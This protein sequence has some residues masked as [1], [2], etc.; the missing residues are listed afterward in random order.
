[1]TAPHDPLADLRAIW[2]S[3]LPTTEKAALTVLVLH[4][5]NGT[6]RCDPSVTRIAAE[7]SLGRRRTFDVLANLTKS[8]VIEPRRRP[9]LRN[10]YTL[11]LELVRPGALVQSTSLVQPTASTGA[12]QCT[13]V[14]HPTAPELRRNYERTTKG[15]GRKRAR[16]VPPTVDEVRAYAIERGRTLDADAFAD[17]FVNYNTAAGWQLSK[18]KP[19]VDWRAAVR[20]WIGRDVEQNAKRFSRRPPQAIR[21]EDDYDAAALAR[22]EVAHA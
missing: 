3:D 22:P 1:M 9:G 11:H 15:A 17:R 20:N 16:F 14:V 7:L 13:G 18:N 21:T 5:N 8:R 4:R 19:M 12:A 6:G 2:S 10:H